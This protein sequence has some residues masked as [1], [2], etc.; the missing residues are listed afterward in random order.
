MTMET[1]LV[2]TPSFRL[3]SFAGRIS[4]IRKLEDYG[5][6]FGFKPGQENLLLDK[7]EK[8]LAIER[9]EYEFNLRREK[10]ISEKIDP[11]PWFLDFLKMMKKGETIQ[12]IKKESL[13]SGRVHYAAKEK[14]TED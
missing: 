1:A 2:G 12:E 5:L 9:R 13:I 14:R 6:A 11:L 4:A 3:S 7:L 10:M 8:V